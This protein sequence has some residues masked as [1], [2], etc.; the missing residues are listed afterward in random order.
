MQL[1]CGCGEQ[2]TEKK[3][4]RADLSSDRKGA[5]ERLQFSPNYPYV[6]MYVCTGEEFSKGMERRKI[7]Q[8]QVM[9][10]KNCVKS[11]R[12]QLVIEG[13]PLTTPLYFFL[14]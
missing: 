14:L 13:F 6:C 2:G 12:L 5:K 8:S 1:F 10:S 11:S 7:L 3:K 4:G 9:E